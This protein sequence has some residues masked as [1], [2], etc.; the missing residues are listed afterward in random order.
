MTHLPLPTSADL[1][2]AAALGCC[3]TIEDHGDGARYRVRPIEGGRFAK[4]VPL[5]GLYDMGDGSLDGGDHPIQLA[6]LLRRMECDM[7]AAEAEARATGRLSKGKLE[8]ILKSA[9]E[10]QELADAVAR[11]TGDRASA[12]PSWVTAPAP[13]SPSGTIH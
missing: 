7:L 8:S 4:V 12:A 3:I 13:F 6:S 9:A 10:A 11:A 1:D 5:D 2:S